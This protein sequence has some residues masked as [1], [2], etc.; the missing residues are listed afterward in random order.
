MKKKPIA[1]V[2]L[3]A[4]KSTRMRSS[5][6]KVLHPLCGRPVL[7]YVLDLVKGIRPQRSVIVLGHKHEQIRPILPAGIKV[8]LQKR[9]LGTADAMKASLGALRSFRGDILVLYGDNPLLRKETVDKLIKRHQS[10]GCA[11]TLLT[12]QMEKPDGYGRIVRDSLFGIKGIVEEKDA[13][14]FERSIKEINTGIMCFSRDALLYALKQI[15]PHNRKKEYYLTDAIGILY[16]AGKLIGGVKIKGSS[17]ALGI[18]SR[19]ELARAGR[20]IHERITEELMKKGVTIVDP[21]SVSISYGVSIGE[22]TVV[23]PFSIIESNVRIGKGASIGPFAHLES[24][25]RV[26]DKAVV[27]PAPDRIKRGRY[28]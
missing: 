9:M 2:V 24:G 28:G 18:N 22:D 8:A 12:A 20:V 21:S 10:G 6:P 26:R 3:A 13:S 11:V 27:G 5:L 25:A 19:V 17:E 23:H 7:G 1:V 4:G 16:A 14:D 15:K